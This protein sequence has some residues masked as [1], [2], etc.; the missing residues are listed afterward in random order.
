MLQIQGQGH[1][2]VYDCKFTPDGQSFAA[3]DS[4]GHLLFFGFGSNEKIKQVTSE[5]SNM[6]DYLVDYK[7]KIC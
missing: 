6:R 2:A 5:L 7:H 3:T 1:G 4:H